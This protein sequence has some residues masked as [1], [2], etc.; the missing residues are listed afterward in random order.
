M[1]PEEQVDTA[2]EN[3]ISRVRARI[4][5][6]KSGN[7][8]G[9]PIVLN[10]INKVLYGVQQARYYLV[11]AD[12]GVGKTTFAD[13]MFVLHGY[14]AAKR[15]GRKLKIF[16]YS[17]EISEEEK[18]AKWICFVSKFLFD[19]PLHMDYVMGRIHGMTVSDEDQEVIDKC[20][21]FL[22]ELLECVTFIDTPKNPTA[23][24]HD[25]IEYAEANGVVKRTDVV[26][27]K[28]L[29]EAGKPK[30]VSYITGF[31]PNDPREIVMYLVDHVALCTSEQG[32]DTKQTMDLLSKYMVFIR[33]KFRFT[34][35]MIQQFNTELQSVERR[36]FKSAALAPQRN[37]F[38]DSKYTYRD[39]DIVFGLLKPSQF[40]IA[41]FYGYSILIGKDNN[42]NY[43]F[44]D[45]FLAV[46]LMKNRYGASGILFP[47]FMD[48]MSGVFKDL[49]PST[50][51][52]EF[53]LETAAEECLQLN[54]INEWFSPKAQ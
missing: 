30:V 38:G 47:L 24:F 7:N 12:S 19:L 2:S 28:V 32:Y 29:D 48:G 1:T 49:P 11:G 53:E 35:V 22:A 43:A 10:N 14:I 8:L 17:F 54:Q 33:N 45:N 4:Q 27:K 31:I 15:E 52:Y 41:E 6:G 50:G 46:F 34:P 25:A 9:L 3:L 44:G 39:A 18:I 37:D 23:I 21:D 20:L 51:D 26:N 42:R 13:F 5:D 40:D 16:Y 36:K